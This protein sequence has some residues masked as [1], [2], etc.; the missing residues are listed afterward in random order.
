[1]ITLREGASTYRMRLCDISQGGRKVQCET[2]FA[3]GSDLVV[4]LAGIEP[5]PGV[6]RRAQ[7]DH[8]GITFNRMLALPVLVEWLEQQREAARNAG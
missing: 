7:G 8:V 6:V 5:Q 1:M 2:G 3:P 4:T